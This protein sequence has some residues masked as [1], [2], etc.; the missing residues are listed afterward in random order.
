MP[1]LG[2]DGAR[3]CVGGFGPDGG[4]GPLASELLKGPILWPPMAFWL[5]AETGILWVP[6]LGVDEVGL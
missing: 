3:I 6:E 1:K 4:T 5:I 2:L